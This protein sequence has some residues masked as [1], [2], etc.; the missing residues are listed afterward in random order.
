[1]DRIRPIDWDRAH[2]QLPGGYLG[3]ILHSGESCQVIATLVPPGAQGPPR[4]KHTSDQIYVVTEGE[5]T[6]ELGTETHRASAC[7]AIFIPAGV[8]HCNRNE[9]D[10]P[11]VHIEVIAPGILPL[12]PVMIPTAETDAHGLPYYV[13]TAGEDSGEVV[14]GMTAEWLVDRAQG[15]EHVAVG[16]AA[17]APGGAGP[18]LHVHDFDQFFF[19]LEGTLSVQIGLE[20]HEAAANSLVVLPAGVPHRQFNERDM[21]ER[22]LAIMAPAPARPYSAEEPWDVAVELAATGGGFE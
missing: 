15:S 21:P 11:E 10:A 16:L 1:M 20:H 12:Y 22:H 8:P 13:R 7:S 5:I 19:V 6:I 18:A 17:V 4:H 9:S 3:Q 2:V 14:P